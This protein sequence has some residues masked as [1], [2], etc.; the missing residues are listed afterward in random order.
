MSAEEDVAHLLERPAFARVGRALVVD[1]DGRPV[2]IVSITNV[3]RAL[4]AARL[5]PHIDDHRHA[6]AR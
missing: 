6:G 5:A 4:R 2:G 1:E 3:Q